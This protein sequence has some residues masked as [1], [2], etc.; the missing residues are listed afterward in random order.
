MQRDAGG[1]FRRPTLVGDRRVEQIAFDRRMRS[2]LGSRPAQCRRTARAMCAACEGPPTA[3]APDAQRDAPCVISRATS[4]AWHRRRAHFGSSETVAEASIASS[5]LSDHVCGAGSGSGGGLT[6]RADSIVAARSLRQI[7]CYSN[8]VARG[9]QGRQLV[10]RST[11]LRY[12]QHRP[13]P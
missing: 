9:T 11:L 4:A 10:R 3:P 1:A 13:D 6:S 2:L 5:G 8:N 12:L 7:R